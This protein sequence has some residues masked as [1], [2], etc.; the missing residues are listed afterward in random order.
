LFFL[1]E[2][3]YIYEKRDKNALTKKKNKINWLFLFFFFFIF[4]IMKI[5][6]FFY[7]KFFENHIFLKTKEKPKSYI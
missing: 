1:G 7:I 2:I 4:Q 5:L 3:N 6:F